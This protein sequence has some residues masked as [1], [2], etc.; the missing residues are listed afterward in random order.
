MFAERF[1][2]NRFLQTKIILEGSINNFL[3]LNVTIVIILINKLLI[4]MVNIWFNYFQKPFYVGNYLIKYKQLYM[5]IN[6]F[7]NLNLR[8]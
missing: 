7:Y 3:Q 8:K 5:C 2:Y 6:P 4:Y 1:L